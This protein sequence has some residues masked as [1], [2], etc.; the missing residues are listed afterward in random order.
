MVLKT[1]SP[2]KKSTP[3]R[4]YL[5]SS[6]QGLSEMEEMLRRKIEETNQKISDYLQ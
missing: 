6:N 5:D 3:S 1:P 2:Q 4:A